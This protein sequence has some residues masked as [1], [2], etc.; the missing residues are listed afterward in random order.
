MLISPHKVRVILPLFQGPLELNT[1]IINGNYCVLIDDSLPIIDK[2][3][4][5]EKLRAIAHKLE[6]EVIDIIEAYNEAYDNQKK[7]LENEHRRG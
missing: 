2:D 7:V 1:M 5:D 6:C 3:G 4:G